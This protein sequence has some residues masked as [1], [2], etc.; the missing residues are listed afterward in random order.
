[1]FQILDWNLLA[2]HFDGNVCNWIQKWFD[3]ELIDFGIFCSRMASVVDFIS[4]QI[5]IGK[6]CWIVNLSDDIEGFDVYFEEY[7]ALFFKNACTL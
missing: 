7:F 6:N 5:V 3:H 4:L 1:M 2:L